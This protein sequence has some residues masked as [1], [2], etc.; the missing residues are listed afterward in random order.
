M[1]ANGNISNNRR[2]ISKAE[3]WRHQSLAAAAWRQKH[4]KSIEEAKQKERKKINEKWGVMAH[5][6]GEWHEMAWHHGG[7]KITAK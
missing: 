6:T 5:E 7:A 4:G 2:K 1:A 3:M